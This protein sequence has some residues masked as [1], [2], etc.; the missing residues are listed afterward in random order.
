M[1]GINNDRR[2]MHFLRMKVAV[3]VVKLDHIYMAEYAQKL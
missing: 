3:S 2:V 1:A